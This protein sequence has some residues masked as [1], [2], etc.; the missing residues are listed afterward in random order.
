MTGNG[1]KWNRLGK[2]FLLI[3]AVLCSLLGAEKALEHWT[4]ECQPHTEVSNFIEVEAKLDSVRYD[5]QSIIVF[6]VEGERNDYI[7]L[8]ETTSLFA[9]Y[10]QLLR[11]QPRCRLW[12]K[13]WS[14][15]R[16]SENWTFVRRL[17]PIWLKPTGFKLILCF[18]DKTEYMMDA[19]NNKNLA[20]LVTQTMRDNIA[21]SDVREELDQMLNGETRPVKAPANNHNSHNSH[22]N[23]SNSNANT[24]S[25]KHETD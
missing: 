21:E 8:R 9:K 6:T 5:R 18:S 20:H 23:H 10:Q 17:K 15:T 25:K 11:S 24:R 19:Q 7:L 14:T 22:N 12:L 3:L 13:L 16:S 1:F 4:E 2:L